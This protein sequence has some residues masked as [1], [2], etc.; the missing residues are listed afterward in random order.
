MDG[1]CL[2]HNDKTQFKHLAL[3][4]LY[5]FSP[6]KLHIHV[7]N[8]PPKKT[9]SPPPPC[10]FGLS[11]FRLQWHWWTVQVRI[12][13]ISPWRIQKTLG[14]VCYKVRIISISA[15]KCPEK[16]R[17]WWEGC[18]SVQVKD[19]VGTPPG[20]ESRQSTVWTEW[21]G[22]SPEDNLLRFDLLLRLGSLV[23]W[24]GTWEAWYLLM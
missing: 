19:V 3:G 10:A 7:A 23:V 9:Y 6:A 2:Y 24:A 1:H 11:V 8:F 21:R 20:P 14:P 13:W 18:C 16:F 22:L 17:L 4:T 15:R 5:Q 12:V